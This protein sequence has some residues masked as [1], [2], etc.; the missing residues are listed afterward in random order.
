MT[1]KSGKGTKPADPNLA[2]KGQTAILFTA[3]EPSGDA[4]AAPIIRQ[5]I[6]QVPDLRIYAWGG[7]LMEEAGASIVQRTATDGAMG[8][9][10][11]S[12]VSS[13]YRE[14]R[15]IKRWS[16]QYRVLAHVPVDA[17]A[18]NFPIC[19]FMRK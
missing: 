19:R 15:R 12:Q 3:F 13:V 4:H 9:N 7:P 5:L 2:S 10:S 11:L 16:N 6:K 18:A 17:P 1:T 8:L 14:L